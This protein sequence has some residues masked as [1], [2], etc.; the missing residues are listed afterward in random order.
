MRSNM[1]RIWPANSSPGVSEAT[2]TRG[3][4]AAWAAASLTCSEARKLTRLSNFS[5]G[6]QEVF[7]LP[8]SPQ[9]ANTGITPAGLISV[10]RIAAAGSFAPISVS[11]GPGP[12][13]PLSP[14]L[15]HAR[16]PDCAA[17]SLP[18]SNCGGTWMSI[19]VG[20]PAEA[21]R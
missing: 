20:E 17:T 19:S 14:N 18:A 21:P 5:F 3:P 15:W 10:R 4:P 7:E 9:G 2:F 11:S 6:R 1:P 13:L 8:G 16:Q 12:S